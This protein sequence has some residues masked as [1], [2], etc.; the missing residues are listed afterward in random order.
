MDKGC[1]RSNY[2]ER[3]FAYFVDVDKSERVKVIYLSLMFFLIIGSYTI[4]KGLKDSLFVSMVGQTY[5]PYAKPMVIFILIPFIFIYSQL[6]DSVRRHQLIYIYSI[7][8]G[9]GF[10]IFAVLLGIPGI[11]LQNTDASPYRILGWLFYF[12]VEGFT[13]FVIALFWS[14]SNSITKP[15]AAKKNYSIMVAGSKIGGMVT[16]GFAWWLFTATDKKLISMS[17]V[18]SHQL[19]MGIASLFLLCVPLMVYLMMKKAPKGSLHGYEAA[20]F[21][22][23]KKEEQVKKNGLITF[24]NDMT[25]GL[26]VLIKHPYVLGI[27]G[28]VFFWEIVNAIFQY[29]R[30]GIGKELTKSASGLSG[31]VFEQDFYAHIVGLLFVFFGTRTLIKLFGIKR[32]LVAVPLLTG[33]LILY[34]IS[35]RSAT[36]VCIVLIIIRAVNYAL[37]SPLRETLYI[38]TTKDT[39]F[40]T[41][42]WIDAFGTKIAKS[43]GQFYNFMTGGIAAAVVFNI[44][45]SFFLLII[46]L[47]SI[48]AY[49]LGKKYESAV[50]NNEVIG[51][52]ESC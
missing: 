44:H 45:L 23:K 48:M 10:A 15:E 31:F 7:V 36:A 46:G 16:A 50:E 41:K 30:L 21:V 5:I 20:Y 40:K 9:I 49:G 52:D 2:F 14:F 25:G 13:P 37:A 28:M 27:F 18:V 3:L 1:V 22:E 51:S 32:S 19:L 34:Y 17:D 43:T 4:A 8:Y 29:M 11:G 39:K 35:A 33:G 47:W 38:P 26:K 42:S 24:W 12:F 6:V